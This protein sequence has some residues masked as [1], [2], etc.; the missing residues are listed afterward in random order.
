M[1]LT[2]TLLNTIAL[3]IILGYGYYS[4]KNNKSKNVKKTT[5]KKESSN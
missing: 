3:T 2:F 5:F 1:A 4:F